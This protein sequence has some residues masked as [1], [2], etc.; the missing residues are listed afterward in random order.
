MGIFSGV[1]KSMDKRQAAWERQQQ[2]RVAR[3]YERG[4]TEACE[5]FRHQL[6]NEVKNMVRDIKEK[7]RLDYNAQVIEREPMPYATDNYEI[8]Q[9]DTSSLVKF[10]KLGYLVDVS[11]KMEF[12]RTL[13]GPIKDEL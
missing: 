4:Y 9:C 8:T 13:R 5:Q 3:A 7:L 2:D 10:R 12:M 6:E 1:F 11:P